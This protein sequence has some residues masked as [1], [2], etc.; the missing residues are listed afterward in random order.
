MKYESF[1]TVAL[2]IKTYM[3]ALIGVVA[4]FIIVAHLLEIPLGGEQSHA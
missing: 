3:Q 2:S 4:F 1:K